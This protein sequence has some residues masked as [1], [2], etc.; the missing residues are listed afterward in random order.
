MYE[1]SDADTMLV[2]GALLIDAEWMAVGIIVGGFAGFCIGGPVG[3]VAGAID[4]GAH[5]LAASVAS[6]Y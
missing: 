6:R 4:G 5:A 3:A 2:S 1:L